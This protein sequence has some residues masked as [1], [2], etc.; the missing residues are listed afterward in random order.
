M[1]WEYCFTYS[2][3]NDV[4]VWMH[5]SSTTWFW[6]H[7][8]ISHS[9]KFQCCINQRTS[10]WI[11]LCIFGLSALFVLSALSFLP[12]Y[13]LWNSQTDVVVS[14]ANLDDIKKSRKTVKFPQNT[15][16]YE[17][18]R[19]VKIHSECFVTHQSGNSEGVCDSNYNCLTEITAVNVLLLM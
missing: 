8:N 3:Y 2:H 16:T 13:K 7:S 5:F 14:Q 15:T 18:I 4:C 17:P 12:S 6:K 10:L 19:M 9:I 11:I 1:F